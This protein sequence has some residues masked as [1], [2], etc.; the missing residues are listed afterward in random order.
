MK[1]QIF[2]LSSP[3]L[4]PLH[5]GLKQLLKNTSKVYNLL[6]VQCP[7]DQFWKMPALQNLEHVRTGLNIKSSHSGQTRE[8]ANIL[9]ETV[10]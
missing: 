6:E 10:E 2:K 1:C 3:L 4:P 8:A 9:K 5:R 7:K